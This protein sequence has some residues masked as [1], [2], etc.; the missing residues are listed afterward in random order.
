M[1]K[2]KRLDLQQGSFK[3]GCGDSVIGADL[4][5][6]RSSGMPWAGRWVDQVVPSWMS[7]SLIFCGVSE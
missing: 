3:L 5:D 1:E 2:R 7:S 6:K 4:V